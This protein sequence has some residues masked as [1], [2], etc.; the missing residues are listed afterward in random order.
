M[1]LIVPQ[2][3]NSV[4]E[5]W[6]TAGMPY[7]DGV[8]LGSPGRKNDAYSGVVDV[9]IDT[10]NFSYVTEGEE[11]SASFFIRNSGVAKLQVSQISTLTEVF[12]IDPEQADVAVGDSVEIEVLFMPPVVGSYV[13]TVTISSDDP[14]TPLVTVV[15]SGSGINEFADISVTDGVTDGITLF[16]FP[17]TR[18]NETW[19][20]TIYVTNLGAP[21]LEIEE[22]F[23][24]GD[25]E[26]STP[27]A[28]GMIAFMDT[29][30][31]PI[32]FSPSA[33]GAYT[34][35]LVLGSNDPDESSYTIVLN[36]ESA[37][38]IILAVPTFFT[39][40]Q[41]AIVAA[42]P[43][44]TVEV[45]SGTYE[46]S[47]DLLDKNLVLRSVAG[48]D[49]TLI[50]GDGTGPVLTISGGQSNLTMV[51][52]FTLTG[53]GG[54]EGGGV[55]VDGEAAPNFKRLILTANSVSGDGAGMLV[56][57]GS[58]T[59]DHVTMSGNTAGGSGGALYA[60]AGSAVTI[61]N[62]ILWNNGTAEIGSSENVAITYSIVSGGA[63]GAIDADPLFVDG[64]ALDFSLQ[65]PSPA[66]DSG[67]PSNNP[68]LDGT[69]SD[70]GAIA[71]DQSYQL[72]DPVVNF[73][74][75]PG[76]GTIQLS[77]SA[78][79]DP[80][81]NV[82]EDIV[83]YTL[84]RGTNSLELDSLDLLSYLD[85]TYL[86][87]GGDAHLINGQE[88]HYSLVPRDTSGLYSVINDTI[89][90]VPAGGTM[91]VNDTVHNFGSVDHNA[92]AS[93]E[94]V[95]SN[96]GNDALTLDTIYTS[97]VWYSVSES[98]VTVPAED[99][100]I[101]LVQ[102]QPGLTPGDLLDTLMITGDDLDN[103]ELYILLSGEGVWPILELSESTLSFGD[104][105]TGI[106]ETMQLTL[107]NTGSD[108]LFVDSIYVADSLSGFSVTLGEMNTSRSLKDRIAISKDRLRGTP[109][110]RTRPR[111][112]KSGRT[113]LSSKNKSFGQ[114]HL[115]NN[116]TDSKNVN[117][118]ARPG[119]FS[120]EG[121][122]VSLGKQSN[123]STPNS[124]L[125]ISSEVM[126]GESI[127]LNVSFMRQDTLTVVDELRITSDDPLGN[128]V[129]SIGLSGRSVAPVLVL[130]ADTLDF[131]HILSESQLSVMVS[132]DGTDTLNVSAISFPT[133]FSGSLEDST[134]APGEAAELTVSIAPEDN[135]YW[136]G[137]I[138]LTS[139]SYQQS[140]HRIVLSALSLNTLLVH[141]FE[142]VL[143]TQTSDTIFTLNNIGNTDLVLDSLSTGQAAFTTDLVNGTIISSGGSQSIVVTFAPTIS[144][145]V[146]GTVVLHTAFGSLAFGTLA[147]D[148]WN[149]PE[150][151][152][153]AKS[154]SAVTYVNNDTDFDIELTNLGDYPLNYTT[155]VDAD[156][157]GWVWLS[158]DEEGNISGNSTALV[159]LSILNTSNLDPGVYSGSIYFGSNTGGSDPDLIITSTD[160][161]DVFLTVL[162]DDSQIADTTVTIAA[163]NTDA[164]VITDENGDL[165]GV[166]LDFVN[167]S[168]GNV[169]VQAID[170][171][172]PVDENTPWVD[173]DGI[174]TEP[175]F[176]EKYFEITTDIEGAFLTDIG[177]NY[178]T[179]IGVSDP[180][181]LRLAKRPG[182]AGLSESWAVIALSDT[183]L[184]ETNGNVVA[185]NQTSFSQWVIISNASDNS[186]MD[187]QGPLIGAVSL[188][189]TAPATGVEVVISANITDDTGI[190]Q[191]TLFYAVGGNW[192]YSSVSMT[193]TGTTYSGTIPA[194]DV[195][196]NG[197]VCYIQSEDATDLA[198]VT[199]S[200]TTALEVLFSGSSI[201]TAVTN[202]QH[203][204]GITMDAWRM[205]S[206]PGVPDD[207]SITANLGNDLGIQDD[208]IWKMFRLSGGTYA[209]NPTTLNSG[210]GYWI[211]QR[212]AE[213]LALNMSAGKS[214]DLDGVSVTVPGGGWTFMSA[215]YPFEI[216][217]N[218]DQATFYGPITYGTIGEGW[219]DVVTTLQPWGGYALYNRTG[220]EQTVLIDPAQGS[221]GLARMTLDDERGW[222]V[223]INAQSGDYFDRYNRF[224]CLES[225][226]NEL[227]WHDNPE[228]TPM[229]DHISM[230]FSSIIENTVVQMTSDLRQ[231]IDQ[232]QV[233]DGEISGSGLTEPVE[234]SWYVEKAPL[235][236]IAMKLIDMNTR[237]VLDLTSPD[238]YLLGDM[239]ER[240]K[241][242]VKIVAGEPEQ[243]ALAVDDILSMIPEELSLDGNYPNPF[244][245]V[246]TIRFGLPEPRN[247]RI[248]VVNILGQEITE[249]V[250]GWR[251][252]GRHEVMWQGVDGSGKAV[253]SGM[254]FTVLSDGN[255]IIVQKMLLLK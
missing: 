177:F 65:W 121:S 32:T 101:I 183:D 163:G 34:A 70:M 174:I 67:D 84:Y 149:W 239:D 208:N 45:L 114:S 77:W 41:E 224:G 100:V 118:P 15:L 8:N 196:Y 17:F 244:N 120:S 229:G 156:F 135:G 248:T 54:T 209:A 112:G 51:N 102:F 50:E 179:L 250:N 211:Y 158:T 72:P 140:E 28:A 253:A 171:Q 13:D 25:A 39:T 164:I 129:I 119:S 247:V 178:T 165:L 18:V 184:D 103:P 22:I 43:E 74:G 86:D 235:G 226:S 33:T 195:T 152:F 238:L 66:I 44:D 115:L 217:I 168:G 128:D 98:S 185:K 233:W 138:L 192:N 154:L 206:L 62:S 231:T 105:R 187:T 246:T 214:G 5:S 251:D 237:R 220:A 212:V 218:L 124:V 155:I 160:T 107:S 242:Q 191:S 76:N 147:G 143:T 241:R 82:N 97:S 232:V 73:S 225:A 255:K 210:E 10:I 24:E 69:I 35:N 2:W 216:N 75:V 49:S 6:V 83:D 20:D 161:V 153:S 94:M 37:E 89:S 42:Y 188:S 139:D 181:T 23:L 48:P 215:P 202:S 63:D 136:T 38:H 36:G 170:A 57:S 223:A 61:D 117:T 132:N 213:N 95:I 55:L 234:I 205:I 19:T 142:G 1:E 199:R 219:T 172:P 85:T 133:G 236:D 190:S 68:D 113:G 141:D 180:S 59:L 26:F 245:P 30:V 11:Q 159:T 60:A 173:L 29:L 64:S 80:R 198:Y 58:V 162:G 27:G 90:L 194:S 116:N 78:P 189:P 110:D 126:P 157:G 12:S 92:L 182:N 9:S 93:W 201:T 228:M 96:S 88:Y 243:V 79:V 14:Y 254:Y 221:G 166:T 197:L 52:G 3:D 240:Y 167:S 134:L 151:Q 127:G 46:E 125:T 252:M 186:F 53:G 47:L 71:F 56:L 148:G 130:A 4:S 104:I 122:A 108:T 109:S 31:V 7:G 81:G 200:D 204:N 227:D 111:G 99:S 131:G 203:P 249:L 91:A 123:Q 176:P 150:A 146:G 230:Y 193:N 169:T 144:D 40:I 16:N 106:T 222:Q 21:D 145:T 87:D 175:V 137:D 207:K